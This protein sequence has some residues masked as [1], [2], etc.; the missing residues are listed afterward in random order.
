M[1]NRTRNK[2]IP[3]MKGAVKVIPNVGDCNPM[4][5]KRGGISEDFMAEYGNATVV[6]TI[7]NLTTKKT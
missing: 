6:F 3:N 1:T 7:L 2:A 4:N 5:V